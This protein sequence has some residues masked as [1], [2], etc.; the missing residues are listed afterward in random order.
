MSL[1]SEKRRRTEESDGSRVS[2]RLEH[3][4]EGSKSVDLFRSGADS[5]Q[6]SQDLK[7]GGEGERLARLYVER[8]E[9]VEDQARD[10]LTTPSELESGKPKRR[11][12]VGEDDLRG[13][14][15]RSKEG[16]REEGARG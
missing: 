1:A 5:D 2:R 10:Q 16:K 14:K 7:G 11:S 4:D 13:L 12:N 9:R 6:T 8:G 15:G 3:S